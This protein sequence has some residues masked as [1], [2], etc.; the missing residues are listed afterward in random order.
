MQDENK[1]AYS[2]E[3]HGM[4]YN[5]YGYAVQLNI[6]YILPNNGSGVQERLNTRHISWEFKNDAEFG[7]F[8]S[9]FNGLEEGVLSLI[10]YDFIRENGMKSIE[11]NGR[12]ESSKDDVISADRLF[13][14]AK[15]FESMGK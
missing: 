8:K 15:F 9:F 7:E 6:T 3:S 10:A 12:G 4:K 13:D 1:I 14:I 2:Y 5:S 11:A